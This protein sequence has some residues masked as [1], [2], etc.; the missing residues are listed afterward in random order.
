MKTAV[1]TVAV[2]VGLD[3]LSVS[4]HSMEA[5]ASRVGAEFIALT[6]VTCPPFPM[7][8]KWQVYDLFDSYERILFLDADV[9]VRGTAPNLFEIVPED[10]IGVYDEFGVMPSKGWLHAEYA[11]IQQDQRLPVR[12]VEH[13][14]NTGLVMSSARH[15]EIWKQPNF[16]R[17]THTYEQSLINLKID[18]N[19]FKVYALD[20]EIHWE[21]WTD[22]EKKH[23]DQGQF[24]HFA[25]LK[26]HAER[27]AMMK[28]AASGNAVAT[29]TD[30]T[31][32]GCGCGQKKPMPVKI[33]K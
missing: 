17:P 18:F 28:D 31:K 10:K 1:V 7:G 8:E 6:N 25:G 2:G 27:L 32:R 12:N 26:D 19:G 24:L 13:C 5:Y 16:F 9:V 33:I 3:W 14:Y 30:K 21:W 20:R 22:R 15:R 4:R 23:Y 11:V 29:A